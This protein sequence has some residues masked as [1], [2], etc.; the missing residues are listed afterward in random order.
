M[1]KELEAQIEARKQEAKDKKISDK[2]SLV[3][4]VLGNH[5]DETTSNS[6]LRCF[7]FTDGNMQIETMSGYCGHCRDAMGVSHKQINYKDKMVFYE[8]GSDIETYI[9]GPWEGLLTKLANKAKKVEETSS[10][11]AFV[12]QTAE[13]IDAEKQIKDRYGL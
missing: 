2:L 10:K 9:P 12:R 4:R 5:Y 13:E 6:N 3:M 7:I 1:N 11:D 8:G